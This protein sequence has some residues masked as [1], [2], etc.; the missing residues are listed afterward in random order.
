M[1]RG[2]LRGYCHCVKI[3]G[4]SAFALV[5]LVSSALATTLYSINWLSDPE[6][7]PPVMASSYARAAAGGRRDGLLIKTELAA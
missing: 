4:I 7:C 6:P 2:R 3:L 5:S 1:P